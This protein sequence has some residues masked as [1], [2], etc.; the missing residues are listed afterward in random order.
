MA[1]WYA[2]QRLPVG[3]GGTVCRIP[4]E[5]EVMVGALPDHCSLLADA[6]ADLLGEPARRRR[7]LVVVPTRGRPHRAARQLRAV[8]EE[9]DILLLATAP[10]DLPAKLTRRSGVRC[11][12]GAYPALD[13]PSFPTPH[14]DLAAKRNFG[15][16]TARR[17]GYDATI[18]IDDDIDIGPEDLR[19]MV[20]ALNTHDIVGRRSVGLADHSVLYRVLSRAGLVKPFISGSC[21]ATRAEYS[22]KFPNIYNEDWFFMW[23]ALGHRG[24]GR[25]GDVR[26]V[27]LEAESGNQLGRAATEELGD[28]LAEG[29]LR[30]LHEAARVGQRGPAEASLGAEEYW[31]DALSRRLFLYELAYTLLAES[32]WPDRDVLMENLRSGHRVLAE[33][34]TTQLA[35]SAVELSAFSPGSAVCGTTRTA[36]GVGGKSYS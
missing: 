35:A 12:V 26:Q 28:V 1:D 27:K 7:V 11:E 18:F 16:V 3:R 34:S 36:A 23:P 19:L 25:L 17:E 6:T 21:M 29:F 9:Y 2:Y 24:V 4:F 15:M 10:Q 5:D 8:P 14:P 31:A 13:G 22:G 32:R 20:T 33:F 30:T